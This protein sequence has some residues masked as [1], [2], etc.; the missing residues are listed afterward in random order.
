M[1]NNKK[2]IAGFIPNLKPTKAIK[3]VKISE[4]VWAAPATS[5]VFPDKIPITKL[6][7]FRIIFPN[8]ST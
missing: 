1:I 2:K 5:A 8:M 3:E 7:V 4:R 6:N